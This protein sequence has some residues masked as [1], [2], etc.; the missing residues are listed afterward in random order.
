VDASCY[1]VISLC[2]MSP[3]VCLLLSSATAGVGGGSV[4]DIILT[5]SVLRGMIEYK[6]D[7]CK[8]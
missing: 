1:P 5:F 6:D 4:T 2:A 7:M 8:Q 3:S